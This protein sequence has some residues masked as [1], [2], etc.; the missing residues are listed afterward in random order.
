MVPDRYKDLISFRKNIEPF[1]QAIRQVHSD[2]PEA[3]PQ[4]SNFNTKDADFPSRITN[5]AKYAQLK[6]HFVQTELC[7]SPDDQ[8]PG[9][10]FFFDRDN[11]NHTFFYL[12]K[13]DDLYKRITKHFLTFDPFFYASAFP[14]NLD[15]YYSDCIRIYAEGIYAKQRK[16]YDRQF[17][18]YKLS[19]F[20]QIGWISTPSLLDADLLKLVES[21]AIFFYKPLANGTRGRMTG[22]QSSA[23]ILQD[24]KSIV[25]DWLAG[26]ST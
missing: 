5:A 11:A 18:A 1:F 26:N 14:H 4:R 7:L 3:L 12:G 17:A 20:R 19:P 13:A 9:L 8:Y 23:E 10:Y 6:D 21:N 22:N 15:K 25:S 16:L 2:N 24:V